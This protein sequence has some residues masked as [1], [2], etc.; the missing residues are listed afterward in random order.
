[1]ELAPLDIKLIWESDADEA[2]A[3]MSNGLSPSLVIM[4][5][6]HHGVNKGPELAKT[7]ESCGIPYIVMTSHNT[8]QVY[9]EMTSFNPEAF[10]SKPI[11][12]LSLKY[13]I[14]KFLEESLIESSEE[15]LSGIYVR[16]KSALIK[17]K[18]EEILYFHGEGNYV[19][20]VTEHE[21][22]VHRKSLIR[23]KEEIPQNLF[24]R[25]HRNYIIR[26]DRVD[27][28]DLSLSTVEIHDIKIPIGRS[29]KRQLKD[30]IS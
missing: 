15:K 18:F 21:K 6:I 14:T 2:M 27:K 8:M 19:T 22:F 16:K 17:I 7:C 4:D 1:M 29:Y 30:S 9:R 5:L 28:V 12:Y 24:I 3:N 26:L 13:F 20:I 11:D 25:I 10:Y 23:L